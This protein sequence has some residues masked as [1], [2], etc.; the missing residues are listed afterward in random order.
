LQTAGSLGLRSYLSGGFTGPLP[1]D[2]YWDDLS[3]GPVVPAA[4]T[5]LTAGAA[6][7][8]E[9]DLNWTNNA[10]AATAFEVDRSADGNTW[11]VLTSSLPG[12]ATGYQDTGLTANTTYFYRVQAIN[13]AGGSG[14]SNVASATTILLVRD[15]FNRAVGSG[16]GTPDLAKPGL[17]WQTTTGSP[18]SL[19]VGP[20]FA[21]S[22]G[23]GKQTTIVN[24]QT[25]QSTLALNQQNLSATVRVAADQIAV[26]GNLHFYIFLR[27]IDDYNWYRLGVSF[28]PDSSAWL[29]LETRTGNSTNYT[30]TTL[31]SQPISGVSYAPNTYF[32][33]KLQVFST[34]A[35]ATTVRGKIWQ[36]GTPEPSGF[37]ET[38]VG[39]TTPALQTAGSLGLR[40]YLSGAYTG[41]LPVDFYWDDLT[42]SALTPS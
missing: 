37:Q 39:E 38:Y 5:N 7:A 2:F 17:T 13:A 26:G 33:L 40:C 32:W 28:T 19:S 25:L 23:A 30:E 10:D 29:N 22:A 18:S 12:T 4:P 42:V 1:V 3:A 21:G 11:S 14:Y 15:S 6:S 41:S 34:G 16:W 27:Y 24:D 36:D 31:A 35:T 9:I 20:D 8:S